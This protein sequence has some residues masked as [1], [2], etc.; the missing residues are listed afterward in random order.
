MVLEEH[1]EKGCSKESTPEVL[2]TVLSAF[3][4]WTEDQ[5]H[6]Q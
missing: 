1:P 2:L 3:A 4:L 5:L 6:Y